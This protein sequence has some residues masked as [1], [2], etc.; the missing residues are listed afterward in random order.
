MICWLRRPYLVPLEP[1]LLQADIAI[2]QCE[3][4]LKVLMGMDASVAIGPDV[5]LRE[6]QR[7]M[8]GYQLEN[9]YNLDRNTTMRSLAIQT[10]LLKQNVTLKK[11]AWIPTLAASYGLSWTAMSSGNAFRDQR[12][13]PYSTVSLALSV[14]IFNGLG[15][16]NGLKQA[17]VQLKEIEFTRENAESSLKMQVELALDN[18]S[19]QVQQIASSEEGV[20]Q[21]DKAREIMQK[22]FEIGAASYLNLRDSEVAA[23]SAHLAYYQSIYNYLI[24]VSELD[25][26]LGR[27]EA[28][29]IT[30]STNR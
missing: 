9:G 8:Y 25:T 27:E 15:R 22:S 4:Q 12:F 11:F 30:T 1:E 20:R 17:Q 6:M 28:L 10:D 24:S 13:N 21:A 26:L 19:R 2:K 23:T 16:L 14:P 5:T 7:E 18:I 29:G 3:L